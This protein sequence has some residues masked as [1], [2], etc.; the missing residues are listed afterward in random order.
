M[1]AVAL[2]G[3]IY[4]YNM[5]FD[6]LTQHYEAAAPYQPTNITQPSKMQH[7]SKSAGNITIQPPAR[8]TCCCIHVH[9]QS[10]A[11]ACSQLRQ[12]QMPLIYCIGPMPQAGLV[13]TPES[14]A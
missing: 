14:A 2:Q 5:F 8:I 6:E 4:Q 12:Q 11:Q 13:S 9:L 3:A 1:G 10:Q 7:T